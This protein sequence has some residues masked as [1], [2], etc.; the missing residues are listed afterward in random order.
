M[1]TPIL[2]SLLSTV[3]LMAVLL[4]GG[5]ASLAHIAFFT[6]TAL[7][8]VLL[9]KGLVDGVKDKRKVVEP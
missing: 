4:I 8:L 6:L 1:R 5:F 7:F 9:V 3:S 2:L